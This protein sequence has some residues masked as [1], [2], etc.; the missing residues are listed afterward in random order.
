MEHGAA[1]PGEVVLS[2]VLAC[3]GVPERL[4]ERLAAI[5]LACHGIDAEVIVVHSSATAVSLPGGSGIPTSL[6]PT[7]SDLVPV[8]WGQGMARA[9]GKIVALTTTQF[10]VSEHWAR[11]FIA[12]MERRGLAAAGG[13]VK[14]SD[15]ARSLEHAV[16][17]IRYSEHMGSDGIEGPREIAGDNAAY[18]K[19]AV[20]RVF[21]H[22][23]SGFWE[24]DVHR[25][26]RA[27]GLVIGRVPEAVA[28]FSP[29]LSMSDM[30]ANRFTHG[31]HFGAYRVRALGWPR[32]RAIAVTPLVPVVLLARIFRR[33]RRGGQSLAPLLVLSPMIV[34]LLG[35]WAAGEARGAITGARNKP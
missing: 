17:L 24:V 20:A 7:T 15:K 11:T 5:E 26:L 8:L 32:W 21:P 35:A 19:D 13:R 2:V 34:L 22:Y 12:E 1:A 14:L 31:S 23:A 10:T 3:D 27:A 9:R 29:S 18:L 28:E 6:L 4:D 16:F 33:V 25:E 30:L